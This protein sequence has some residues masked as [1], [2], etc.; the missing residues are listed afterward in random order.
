MKPRTNPESAFTLTELLI[1]VA[2]IGIVSAM[3]VP[4]LGQVG[5]SIKLGQAA[6]DVERELQTARM[7]AV[8]SNASR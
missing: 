2:L 5:D 8:S 3:A 1:V 6:R 4:L 7:R